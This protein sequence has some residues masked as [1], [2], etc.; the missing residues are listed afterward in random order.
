MVKS[1]T[2]PRRVKRGVAEDTTRPARG[3]FS[4]DVM[5]RCIRYTMYNITKHSSHLDDTLYLYP[6]SWSRTASRL[7]LDALH[8]GRAVK[9]LLQS[10]SRA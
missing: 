6:S 10:I 5:R 9:V 2:R 3:V 4:S 1:I 8:T 7:R